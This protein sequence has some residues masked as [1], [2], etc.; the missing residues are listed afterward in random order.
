MYKVL[1]VPELATITAMGGHDIR[2][3]PD[4]EKH[5]AFSVYTANKKLLLAQQCDLEDYFINLARLSP[6]RDAVIV[7]DRGYLDD[8]AYMSKEAYEFFVKT[9]GV[10]VEE[11]RDTRYDMVVHMVT[12]ANGAPDHYTLANNKART[13]GIEEAIAIDNRIKEVWNGHPNHMYQKFI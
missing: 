1:L 11:I 10:S 9:T 6:D 3:T 5:V 2:P 13:E 4:V 12:A 7:Y 8:I